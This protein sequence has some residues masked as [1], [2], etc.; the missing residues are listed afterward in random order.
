MIS[1]GDEP[2]I[3]LNTADN[4]ARFHEVRFSNADKD[5]ELNQRLGFIKET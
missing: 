4:F 5:K 2:V 3:Y 1:N